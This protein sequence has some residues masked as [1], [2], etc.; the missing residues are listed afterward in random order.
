MPALYIPTYATSALGLSPFQGTLVLAL[1]NLSQAGGYPLFGL[2]AFVPPFA[3]V[4][5]CC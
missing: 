3:R 1:M 2:R 4:S 5:C